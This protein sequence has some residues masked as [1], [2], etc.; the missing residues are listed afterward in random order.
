M[1]DQ[2]DPNLFQILNIFGVFEY[3]EVGNGG[4]IVSAANLKEG[5]TYKLVVSN[6][7]VGVWR[8]NLQ[9]LVQHVG[10]H[11]VTSNPIVRYIGRDGGLRLVPSFVSEQQLK[12]AA[13][14]VFKTTNKALVKEFVT[15]ADNS[16]PN[17][18]VGFCFEAADEN[19]TLDTGVWEDILT[20]SLREQN[21]RFEQ[22]YGDKLRKCVVR[23]LRSG[24]F[25]EYRA[26]RAEVVGSGQVKIPVV[27][28]A[29]ETKEWFL[30][31]CLQCF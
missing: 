15:F 22:F 26:W 19:R 31:R 10:Y 1:Q 11:P 30:A 3:L 17:E 27:I 25:A 9:D 20:V 23:V 4:A 16:E 18:A 7:R 13:D 12:R 5:Q 21:E 8:Y 14:A 24:T 28:Q 29:L 2:S 6:K